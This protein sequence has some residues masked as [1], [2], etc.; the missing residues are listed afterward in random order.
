MSIADTFENGLRIPQIEGALRIFDQRRILLADQPGAGKTAQALV[1]LELDDAFRNPN[2]ATLIMCNVTG[3][4]LTWAGELKARVA[5]Q[6]DVAIIDLTDTGGRKTMPSVAARNTQLASEYMAA[7]DAGRPV[8]VLINF[9]LLRWP[10]KGEPKMRNLFL[11]DFDAVIID[12]GHLVLPTK[13]APGAAG[14]TQFWRGLRH[15]K[16]TSNAIL[17]SITGTPD[18]G[19]LHNRFG[20]WRFLW[21]HLFSDFWPWVRQ[22]FVVTDGE[23]GGVEIGKLRNEHAWQSFDR[24]HMIRRTKAEMLKGLPP[25]AWANKGGID[26]QMTPDQ[27]AAYF[28]YLDEIE[29][30]RMELIAQ[31][32][33]ESVAEAQALQMAYALRAR[34][35]A[36]CTWTFE[37]YEGTDGKKHTRGTPIVAGPSHSNKLA[38][39]LQWLDERCYLPDGFDPS[40]GKVVIA[41]YF[42]QVLHWLQKELKAAG[43]EAEILAGDTPAPQKKQ[44]EERFQRGELRIVLL[45]GHLGVSINLDAADDM[46][47]V[48]SIHDP[49]KMEQAEDRIHRASRNH[50]VTYWRLASKDTIDMATLALIDSRYRETRKSYDGARGVEFARLMLHGAPRL[51]EEQLVA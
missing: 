28:D 8:I 35:L 33:K 14:E 31:D 36:T 12:E 40:Q 23:W 48:D 6:Y 21:S 38:W 27:E 29:Q 47:F 37:E 44:I 3:C 2:Y 9:D 46:I 19:K 41:S 51:A 26:L 11:I 15:L 4:Q 50:H 10:P 22:N 25:K 30:R 43:V 45:S 5:S 39:I 20:H 49:D 17:L 32:T 24:S 18:R 34:Q 1:A 42:T 13:A 7:R 16:V